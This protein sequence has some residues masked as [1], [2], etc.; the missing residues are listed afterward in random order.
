MHFLWRNRAMS[1]IKINELTNQESMVQHLTD[2]ESA[3]V[4]GG[5]K[6]GN[7][8]GGGEGGGND[9]VDAFIQKC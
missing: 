6:G 9:G 2:K 4:V 7:K 1:I 3:K 8:Y 5:K